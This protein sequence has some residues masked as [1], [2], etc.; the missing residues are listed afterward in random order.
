MG[1]IMLFGMLRENIQTVFGKDL[2]AEALSLVLKEQDK[3][4]ERL[5]GVENSAMITRLKE[6]E[7][8]E[9]RQMKGTAKV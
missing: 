2:A 4:R 7:F 3:L 5:K 9:R 1:H 8:M 6:D